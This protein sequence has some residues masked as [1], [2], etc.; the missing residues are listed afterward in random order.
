MPFA[1]ARQLIDASA[2]VAIASNCN[3]GTSFT[4]AMSFAVATAVLQMR[5]SVSEAVTAATL[6]GAV[7][8]GMDVDGWRD[9]GGVPQPRVG[10]VS[11]GARGDLQVLEAPSVT[12]IAYRPGVPLTVA[13]WKAGKRLR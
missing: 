11:L 2:V 12:H 4:T 8:L 3:P 5:L 10:S 6:G 9:P 1:P 13:V 7:A